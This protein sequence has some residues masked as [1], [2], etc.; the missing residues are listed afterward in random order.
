MLVQDGAHVSIHD[1]TAPTTAASD[2]T[3][4]KVQK[5]RFV[6]GKAVSKRLEN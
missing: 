3:T 4:P 1:V 6:I 5:H 2:E